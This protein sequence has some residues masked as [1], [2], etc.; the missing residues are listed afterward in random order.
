MAIAKFW[1]F[2]FRYPA[3]LVGEIDCSCV[4]DDLKWFWTKMRCVKDMKIRRHEVLAVLYNVV[5]EWC[6][7]EDGAWCLKQPDFATAHTSITS[8]LVFC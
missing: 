2:S 6:T 5:G 3:L 8:K 7:S 1:D 4:A